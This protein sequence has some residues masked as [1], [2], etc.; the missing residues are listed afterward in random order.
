M[1]LKLG[2]SKSTSSSNSASNTSS[3]SNSTLNSDTNTTTNSATDA[4]GLSN[5]LNGSAFTSTST[6]NVP[7]WASDLTQSIAGQ[8]G[9]LTSLDP[10]SLVAPANSLQTQ[11]ATAAG[12]LNSLPWNFN[13]AADLTRQAGDTSWTQPYLDA[14]RLVVSGGKASDWVG[15]YMDPYQQQVVDATS[16]DLDAN[17]GRVRAQ[18][19][20]QLAGSGAFGGSGAALT[21]SMTEGELARARATTLGQLRSQGYQTALNAASGDAERA[22]Q[23]RV[24]NAQN[25]LQL[26]QQKAQ[27]QLQAG[28]QQLQAANQLAGLSS[29]YDANQRADIG[30]QQQLGDDLRGIDQQQLSAPVTSTQQIVA[31]LS[32]LPIQLF[33]GQTQSG[34]QV[35]GSTSASSNSS[36]TVGSTDSTTSGTS[37]TATSGT[38][39]SSASGTNTNVSAGLDLPLPNPFLP[40][41]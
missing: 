14:N 17:D 2:G 5:T 8:V 1:S 22:T 29:Q 3:N 16:A 7:S 36:N 21:Q 12:G 35:G 41:K 23:A 31:M 24:A 25:A 27:L 33:T 19:A 6:P 4:A 15:N 39:N 9:G 10:Q 11:A 37:S 20:L 18:Q 28:Q 34:S 26:Q 32:G 13:T 30:A 38:S 40:S